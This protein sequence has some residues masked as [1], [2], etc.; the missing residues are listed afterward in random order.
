MHPQDLQAALWFSGI[1]FALSILAVVLS[2]ASV[3]APADNVRQTHVEGYILTPKEVEVTPEVPEVTAEAPK[4]TPP[5]PVVTPVSS[6]TAEPAP[7]TPQPEPLAEP[8][9]WPTMRY[10]GNYNGYGMYTAY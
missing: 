1:A 4:V 8:Y 10:W 9:K 2:L 7:V 3:F 5:T 6:E